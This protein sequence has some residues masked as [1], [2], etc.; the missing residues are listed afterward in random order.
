MNRRNFIRTGVAAAS[1]AL[2]AFARA[3]SPAPLS[4]PAPTA[5]GPVEFAP[6]PDSGWRRFEVKTRIEPLAGDGATRVWVPLPS[7]NEAD[8]QRPMGNLWQ[9]NADFMTLVRD[10]S[11]AEMLYAEWA[12]GGALPELEV[13][14]RFATR[15][16]AT[17]FASPSAERLSLPREQRALYT[18]A[19]AL[20][21]TDGIVR[22][23]ARDIVRGAK[24][25]EDKARAIYEWIVDNTF[26]DPKVRGCGNGDIR[27][28]IETGNLSGKCADLNALYVGLARAAGLPAR[29]VY[30]IRVADSRFG[31]K[32]LGKSG[33][34]SKAQHCRAEVFLERFG[35][36]P[37]DPADVRKVVLEEPPGNLSMIDPKVIAAR[38]RLFGAW[39][40]NWL[41]Y[42]DAHDLRLP[43]SSGGEIPFLMYPQG[44]A[45][46]E[47]FDSLDPDAFRYTLTATELG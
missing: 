35:W 27:T 1:L 20:L 43:N 6:T 37:V 15:D 31:Y 19:T 21:P 10:A 26:R 14:S 42:N 24:T 16:R 44:E 34:I 11:G 45:N 32:S 39:E 25:D 47:R 2:P 28:M 38:K 46:G 33:T 9:G 7:M 22:D 30:G 23:T 13:V 41:A 17:D 29:D 18:R 12:P 3:N 36:V 8:W 40:M 5:A 4:T